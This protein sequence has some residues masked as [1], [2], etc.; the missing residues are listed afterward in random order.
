MV[1][2]IGVVCG[3]VHAARQA[4]EARDDPKQSVG[5]SR[6]SPHGRKAVAKTG[7]I[8]IGSVHTLGDP[9]HTFASQRL[10]LAVVRKSEGCGKSETLKV[11]AHDVKVK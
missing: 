9:L 5:K 6:I 8:G 10:Q 11:F 1:K 2:Q 7:K 3:N 4:F